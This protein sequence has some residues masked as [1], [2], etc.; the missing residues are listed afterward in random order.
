MNYPQNLYE[1]LYNRT[2]LRTPQIGPI[3]YMD[4][5]ENVKEWEEKVESTIADFFRRDNIEEKQCMLAI[6]K[7]FKFDET[8]DNIARFLDI[9]VY[10]AKKRINQGLDLLYD[11]MYIKSDMFNPDKKKISEMSDDEFENYY[12]ESLICRNLSTRLSHALA[13]ASINNVQSLAY[14]L[15]FK[16]NWKSRGGYLFPAPD[17]IKNYQK[18][19]IRNF[20]RKGYEELWEKC[21][22][23]QVNRRLGL[24]YGAT[25]RLKEDA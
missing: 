21:Q 10:L 23:M 11:Y 16:H 17:E 6:I 5:E 14:M 8:Y 2:F 9:S 19:N 1:E 22:L 4:R 7:R 20:G 3:N 13:R 25:K 24:P 15:G 18:F 12:K